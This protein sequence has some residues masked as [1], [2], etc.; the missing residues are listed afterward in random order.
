[1]PREPTG[2]NGPSTTTF[3][4]PVGPSDIHKQDENKKRSRGP[5]SCA[6][7]RRLKLKCDRRLPCSSCTKRG[8][9]A[10][11][12][13]GTLAAGPGNRFVLADTQ[14]L[15]EKIEAMSRRIEQLEDALAALQSQISHEKHPLL[16][17]ELMLLK[18]PPPTENVAA[19][20]NDATDKITECLGTLTLGERGHFFGNHASVDYLI[21]E[22][23]PAE[24][25]ASACALPIDTLLLA[26]A[27]PMTSIRD[28]REKVTLKLA[29]WLPPAALAW[30]LVEKYYSDAAW[31]YVL[32]SKAEFS[33]TIFTRVYGTDPPSV[34][35]VSSHEMAMLYMVL[36][37][38]C[39]VDMT[40]PPYCVEASNYYQLAR[41]A[42]GLDSVI[43]HPTIHAVIAIHLMSTF[44][45][46][47]DHQN[48]AT[49][50]YSLLG[51]NAQL[52]YSLGLHRDDTQWKLP[53]SEQQKRRHVFWEV[54]CHD[55]WSSLSFGRPPSFSPA[56]VDA[57]V[58][59]D[60]EKV[61]NSEGD[62]EVQF[63]HWSHTFIQQV[64]LKVM[65]QAFGVTPLA[66][67][68]VLRLDR[69][70]REH[71]LNGALRIINVGQCEPGIS[72]GLLLQRNTVFALT[73]RLLLFLHRGFFAQ[74]LLEHSDDPLKSKYA[75][76]VLAT[77]RC[78][79]YITASVRALY[80][81]VPLALR[82]WVFWSQS[83]SACLMLGSV[84]IKAPGS[85]LAP[86][87]WVELDRMFELFEQVA[88]HSQR[89][90]R[91][92]PKMRRLHL[93][94]HEAYTAFSTSKGAPL[95][96]VC[97]PREEQ[98]LL[99]L[100][101]VTRLVD[102]ANKPCGPTTSCFETPRSETSTAHSSPPEVDSSAPKADTIPTAAPVNN[103]QVPHVDA[104]PPSGTAPVTTGSPDLFAELYSSIFPPD[105][106][107][108]PAPQPQ[109]QHPWDPTV[110]SAPGAAP[111]PDSQAPNPVGAFEFPPGPAWDF[112]FA[113][114][115]NLPLPGMSMH[116][117][118]PDV[119]AGIAPVRS[120]LDIP[121]QRFMGTI[122][123]FG[124]DA[125]QQQQQQ[126]GAGHNAFKD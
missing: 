9:A 73:Q 119:M 17:D 122:G 52:C 53:E 16:A 42:L 46:M 120:Q 115:D 91:I 7:C 88:P 6:E 22:E 126:N 87:A 105:L 85:G 61:M 38:G 21:A 32:I 114:L 29:H 64:M 11:C 39:M 116:D 8:C 77:F 31:L 68:T 10:I 67:S 110:F 89:I 81:Q 96:N 12:P 37:I 18:A 20:I 70:V 3:V 57:K 94:A 74:A 69:L 43:D 55:A 98:E 99:Y 44:L 34:L 28:G 2:D 109:P 108:Q 4:P 121:W 15:H 82:Y 104:V 66:Y 41:V 47:T 102:F 35:S 65:D 111:F 45:Q 54:A 51:L 78:A 49:T 14:H 76:S 72:R 118:S 83:F 92:M 62:W 63:R 71:P 23:A 58:A 75:Q 19:A 24:T 100:W 50:C 125:Q 80:A 101:G 26:G 103:A 25:A 5:V 30:Q 36:A 90:A 48:S 40:R 97:T 56:H 33:E 13:N 60:I 86:P 95:P 59:G 113:D 93:R 117:T 112:D 1:M 124:D 27:F 79:F 106:Q 123:V 107:A 84:V